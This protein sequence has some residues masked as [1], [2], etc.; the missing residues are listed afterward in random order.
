MVGIGSTI[1]Y[2]GIY[3]DS[4]TNTILDM[5]GDNATT[6]GTGIYLTN[7]TA[8]IHGRGQGRL[9]WATVEGTAGGIPTMTAKV[10]YYSNNGTNDWGPIVWSTSSASTISQEV[11]WATDGG[12]RL[13]KVF[14]GAYDPQSGWIKPDM[15]T[16]HDRLRRI[17]QQRQAPAFIKDLKALDRAPDIREI[18]ARETLRRVIGEDNYRYFL[19][20]G[21]ITV[22]N[23]KSGN[24][25]QIFPGH[26]I[27]NV[28]FRGKMTERLCVVMRG[29]FPPTDSLIMRY[30]MILNNEEQFRSLANKHTV[31]ETQRNRYHAMLREPDRRPLTEIFAALQG[32][33][34]A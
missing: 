28:Y 4:A 3:L 12:M 13:V 1:S 5:G 21:F 25:F 11:E 27:T 24:T 7:N 30:L 32:K 14:R 2:E 8:R 26:G 17:M 19:R 31:Y 6:D 9:E 16:I 15:P 23:P 20:K 33:K 34:V 29:D 10:R 18:R 22:M